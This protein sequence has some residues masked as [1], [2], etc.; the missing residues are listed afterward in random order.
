MNQMT[1]VNDK[2]FQNRL[3]TLPLKK[4]FCSL[5][6]FGKSKADKGQVMTLESSVRGGRDCVLVNKRQKINNQHEA[7]AHNL[8]SIEC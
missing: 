1:T 7:L 3:K 2:V 5:P 4:P 8:S 6:V